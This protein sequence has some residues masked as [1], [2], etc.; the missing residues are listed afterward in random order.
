MPEDRFAG[1]VAALEDL[2]HLGLGAAL[3]VVADDASAH[4]GAV[5]D[6]AHFLRRE[7]EVGQAPVANDESVPVA[8]AGDGAVDLGHQLVA[9]RARGGR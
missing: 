9:E 3:L 6:A 2:E 1:D 4:P 5:Q 8:V 7:K